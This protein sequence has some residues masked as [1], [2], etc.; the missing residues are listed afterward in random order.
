MCYAA[1][2]SASLK[3]LTVEEFLAWERGQPVRYEFDGGEGAWCRGSKIHR[4]NDAP[5]EPGTPVTV[6]Y[7]PARPRRNLLYRY[8]AYEVMPGP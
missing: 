5:P 7:D 6:V 1:A 8:A 4:G 3:P 2:M